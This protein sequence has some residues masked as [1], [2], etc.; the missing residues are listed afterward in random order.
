[1]CIVYYLLLDVVLSEDAA[2]LC[3]ILIAVVVVVLMNANEI[4]GIS[5]APKTNI[6]FKSRQESGEM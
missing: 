6:L 3:S 5:L 1:M 2:L 4:R